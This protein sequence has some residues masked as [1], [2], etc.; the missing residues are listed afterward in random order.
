MFSSG[1]HLVQNVWP[2]AVVHDYD[3]DPRFLGMGMGQ[4]I[5]ARFPYRKD[6]EAFA[7]GDLFD[8]VEYDPNP[9]DSH[10]LTNMQNPYLLALREDYDNTDATGKRETF[11]FWDMHLNDLWLDSGLPAT[12]HARKVINRF[13]A[14]FG[15]P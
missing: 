6:A 14:V 12:V 4:G 8:T 9:I 2:W 11:A 3:R 10:P 7:A 5:D 13:K 1:K 15:T